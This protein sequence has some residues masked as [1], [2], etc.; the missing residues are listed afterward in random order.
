MLD[1]KQSSYPN[2][3]ENIICYVNIKFYDLALL[4]DYQ[5][6]TIVDVKDSLFRNKDLKL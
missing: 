6:D 2:L 3:L 4:K 1:G 5:D